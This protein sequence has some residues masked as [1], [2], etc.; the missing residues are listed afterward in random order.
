MILL[1]TDHPRPIDRLIDFFGERLPATPTP[2]R[3]VKAAP[4]RAA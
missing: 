1:K 3:P 4:L 2:P